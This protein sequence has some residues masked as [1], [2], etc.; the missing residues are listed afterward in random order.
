[1][2]KILLI[3]SAVLLVGA[4]LGLV[5]THR[6]PEQLETKKEVTLMSYQQQGTFTPHFFVEPS[7][8]AG[9][10]Q[11]LPADARYPAKL[12]NN[13]EV[14]FSYDTPLVQVQEVMVT[15]VLSNP[16]LW[17]KS[18]TILPLTEKTGNFDLD[19]V[20]DTAEYHSRG[21]TID[22]ELGLAAREYQLTISTSIHF[23]EAEEQLYADYSQDMILQLRSDFVEVSPELSRRWGEALGQYR[24]TVSLNPNSLYED[25]AVVVVPLVPREMDE[26]DNIFSN[27]TK[28]M[29]MDYSYKLQSSSPV[30]DQVEEVTLEAIA[31]NTGKWSKT[32]V[33][34]PAT[35]KDGDFSLAIPLDLM[36]LRQVFIDIGAETGMYAQN[37]NLT[38]KANMHVT[39]QSEFGVID[40]TFTQ[41]TAMD[42][43]QG[44]L[45]W[46]GQ[47][48]KTQTGSIRR[49]DTV[50]RDNIYGKLPVA[51]LRIIFIILTVLFA[52]FFGFALYR[53]LRARGEE[54]TSAAEKEAQRITKK[55]K[56]IISDIEGLPVLRDGETVIK[57]NAIEELIKTA[58]GLI[59]PVLHSKEQGK[60]VYIVL[61]EMIRYQYDLLSDEEMEAVKVINLT[62]D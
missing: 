13:I 19:F 1:M 58:E 6:L 14:N 15:A 40:E 55:Y 3:V 38:L 43:S 28:T 8:V 26:G 48:A 53:F 52:G 30:T 54:E 62:G 16:E 37:Y 32:I 27:L 61:D 47:M 50:V 42:L 60:H 17:E 46:S 23:P 44:I 45:K 11:D 41:S 21:K 31:E 24:Y 35:I 29:V 49:T 34:V 59:K 9:D 2:K 33:L 25:S 36:E 20:I 10:Y 12:L 18:Y 4:I 39:A 56:G 22:Q 5:Q 7:L 51:R 57:T